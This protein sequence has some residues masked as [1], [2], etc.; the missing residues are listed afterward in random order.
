MEILGDSMLND[1]QEKG[2]NENTDI[3]I[4]IRKYPDPSSTDILDHIR[5]SLRKEPD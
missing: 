4:K 5:P 2:L 3:N 1:V